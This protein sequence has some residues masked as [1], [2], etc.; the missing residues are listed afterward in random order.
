[1]QYI[2]DAIVFAVFAE[3]N[4][5]DVLNGMCGVISQIYVVGSIRHA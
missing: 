4:I 2:L 1:M 3:W 5:A